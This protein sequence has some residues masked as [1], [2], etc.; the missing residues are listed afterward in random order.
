MNQA[1]LTPLLDWLD[2]AGV[3]VFALTGALAAARARQTFVTMGFFALVTGVG[4]GSV[5]DLLIDAPVFWVHDG[6]IAG[7]CLGTAVLVWITPIHWWQGKLLDY[8]DA[9]GL[10]AYAAL[11]TAK[12]LS[13]GVPPVPAFVMGVVTGCVG[14]IVRDVIAGEP[15]IIMRPELYVTAAALSSAL[16]VIGS[17]VGLPREAAL[18]TAALAGFGLRAAAI[19]WRLALPAYAGAIE[20]PDQSS[21]AGGGEGGGTSASSPGSGPPG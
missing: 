7:V 13:Y 12:A 9:L 11:G 1:V 19:R 15:S 16:C 6:W 18:I 21:G 2:Y 5:R 3:A 8:A 4:G 17:L 10:T 14:G 20:P